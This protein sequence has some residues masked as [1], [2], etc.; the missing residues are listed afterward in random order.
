MPEHSLFKKTIGKKKRQIDVKC[1]TQYCMIGSLE[2][3]TFYPVVSK[4]QE[5]LAWDFCPPAAEK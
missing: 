2:N 1:F 5:A 4:S 3:K